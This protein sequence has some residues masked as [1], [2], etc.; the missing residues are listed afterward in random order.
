MIEAF[1][2][3]VIIRA[4]YTLYIASSHFAKMLGIKCTLLLAFAL[5]T[6]GIDCWQNSKRREEK[7]LDYYW[8]DE[9]F[10]LSSLQGEM[11][12]VYFWPPKPRQRDSCEVIKFRKLVFK[13]ITRLNNECP[14]L[15]LSSEQTIVKASYINSVDKPVDLLYY[16]SDEVKNM[17][18]SCKKDISKYLFISVDDNFVLG[19]NCSADGRGILLSK[20]MPTSEEVL[21]VID[22]EGLMPGREGSPDCQL[23]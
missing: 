19:I 9:N 1:R 21:R 12:A 2:V 20:R 16:G 6:C 5:T 14:S 22:E 18:W 13:E 8:T 15:N 17:Y 4:S 3:E 10:D 23:I 11:I 7:C